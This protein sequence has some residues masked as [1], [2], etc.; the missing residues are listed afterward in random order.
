MK[1]PT[2]QPSGHPEELRK[3]RILTIDDDVSGRVSLQEMFLR[4]GHDCTSA[5][6]GEEGLQILR[7]QGQFDLILC[8]LRMPIMD[9]DLF[10]KHACLENL[11]IHS[12][13]GQ[14]DKTS[15]PHVAFMTAYGD[16]AQAIEL[17]RQG[18]IHFLMK[19]LKKKELELLCQETLRLRAYRLKQAKKA[20]SLPMTPAPPTEF[21][22]KD[23]KSQAVLQ[24]IDQVA[25][26]LASVLITGESGT[27]KELLAK[28]LHEKSLRKN[29]PFVALNAAALPETLLE[30]ELFGYERGAFT[31]AHQEKPGQITLA[32]GGTFFLD[33]ITSMSLSMQSKLLRVIQEKEVRPL[34]SNESKRI[35]VRWVTAANQELESLC[36][37]GKF[38]EDLLYRLRVV[39]VDVHPLRQR[40]GDIEA[41]LDYFCRFFTTPE[42][43][44]L[45]QE[46]SMTKEARMLCKNYDWPGNVRELRNVV[47]R[48]A[49]LCHG[50]LITVRD[51]PKQI[52]EQ[53]LSA[54]AEPEAHI[55]LP[56]GTPLRQIEDHV[57]RQTL[58]L[59]R[60]DKAQAA[61]ILGINLRTV[62]RW[63]ERVDK[64]AV[65]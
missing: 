41:L 10:F 26:T 37:Q 65:E 49:A 20:A 24:L 9:G 40:P 64:P 42:Q 29:G 18:A 62:Y 44:N 53:S 38:R 51:L 54:K 48:G 33:E 39:S 61:Q 1:P 14:R 34:G 25:P 28:R 30:S 60:G 8:D 45:R 46:V 5:A 17:M 12:G 36:D 3:L 11:V 35:D 63:L 47:E 55:V 57:I 58:D 50:G 6:H 43:E 52:L 23:L 4:L 27:G 22:A 59:C 15:R 32:D 31:G 56:F 19:P 2:R 16:L 21:I 7:N 13:Q